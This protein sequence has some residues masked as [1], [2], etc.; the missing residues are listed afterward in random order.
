MTEITKDCIRDFI[1]SWRQY[2]MHGAS[3]PI[4]GNRIEQAAHWNTRFR[5][6]GYYSAQPG[7]LQQWGQI[8]Q[9]CCDQFGEQHYC[10]S[11]STFWF[12]SKKAA[13]LFLL[14]WS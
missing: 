7:N 6:A 13:V 2:D 3:G 11:G 8:H 5:D 12:E 14:R 4:I 1:D 10:W 9:W